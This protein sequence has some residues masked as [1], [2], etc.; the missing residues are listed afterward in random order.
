M[1]N[2]VAFSDTHLLPGKAGDFGEDDS[3]QAA[4][5]RHL[6]HEWRGNSD[7]VVAVGDIGEF[8]QGS[9]EEVIEAYPKTM[10]ALRRTV[11]HYCKGN[12][13]EDATGNFLQ[14][15]PLPYLALDGVW[16]EH[17]HAHDKLIAKLPWLARGVTGV[18]GLLE[19]V[20][21]KDVDRWA[22]RLWH[23]MT[24]TGRY[25]W[26][27][28]NRKYYEP[29]AKA[30]WEYG[31]KQSVFGHTHREGSWTFLEPGAMTDFVEVRNCGTWTGGE[32]GVVRLEV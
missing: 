12:H 29:V 20:W 19:R 6:C 4:H 24:R 17:G 9:E 7:I 15:E 14:L 27:D 28:R 8:W 30:G 3:D 23:R 11:K 18:V 16:F 2:I 21:H 13:D 26:G 32:R 5:L 10:D 1:S 22:S 31:C 25:G